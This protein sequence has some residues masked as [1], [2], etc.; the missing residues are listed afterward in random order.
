MHPQFTDRVAQVVKLAGAIAR[1]RGLEY[2]GTEHILLAIRQEGGGLGSKLLADRGISLEMLRTEIDKL[3]Q[4]SMEDT[5]VFGR[6]PGSPHF[7]N[8][9][10]TALEEAEKTKSSKLRTEHLVLA[11][12]KEEGSVACRALRTL[13]CDYAEVHAD[14][15]AQAHTAPAE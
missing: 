10:A 9:V 4:K 8:V 6:L 15:A 14:V 11:L 1:E 5:W 3:V 2:V 13:G 12:L 7:R